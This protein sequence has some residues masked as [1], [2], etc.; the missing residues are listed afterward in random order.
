MNSLKVNKRSIPKKKVFSISD[1]LKFKKFPFSTKAYPGFLSRIESVD[2]LSI[3]RIRN[4]LTAFYSKTQIPLLINK[5]FNINGEPV[6]CSLVD[7]YRCMMSS[8]IDYILL[9]N[10]LVSKSK[11]PKWFKKTN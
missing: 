5:S 3:P 2:K 6:V 11:Q 7:A 8:D 9:E 4:I 10:I 1:L